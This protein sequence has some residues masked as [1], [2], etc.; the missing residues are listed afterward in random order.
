MALSHLKGTRHW[1]QS[2]LPKGTT[3]AASRFKLGT[4]PLYDHGLIHWAMTVPQK[5]EINEWDD[6]RLWM[7][8]HKEGGEYHWTISSPHCSHQRL[9]QWIKLFNFSI[10]CILS[11]RSHNLHIL[12]HNI[13][14][15]PPWSTS[16]LP[17]FYRAVPSPAHF[18]LPLACLNPLS[19]TPHENVVWCNNSWLGFLKI[20]HYVPQ[21]SLE[22][23]ILQKMSPHLSQFNVAMAHRNYFRWN[24]LWILKLATYTKIKD[25]Y[26]RC[27]LAIF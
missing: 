17:T 12:P 21:E 1:G 9:S 19:T 26:F 7:G 27:K 24:N 10:P 4:S 6:F 5:K 25:H 13:H 22:K 3:A 2:A 8:L 14:R 15:P 23:N 16:L 20:L 18:P 11:H